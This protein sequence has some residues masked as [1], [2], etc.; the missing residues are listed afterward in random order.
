MLD[1]SQSV[2]TAVK[3]DSPHKTPQGP[4]NMQKIQPERTVESMEHPAGILET[5]A[6]VEMA[7][8]I[9]TTFGTW[10]LTRG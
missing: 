3:A 1:A 5:G 4:G 2:E 8:K 6:K 9:H 10:H 7:R